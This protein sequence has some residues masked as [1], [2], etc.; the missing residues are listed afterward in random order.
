MRI[1]ITAFSLLFTLSLSAQDFRATAPEP[2]PAPEIELGDFQDF[3]L[4]NGLQ[5]VLVENHKLPR[6][7]YQLFVD[8]PPHLEGGYAGAGDIFGQLLRRATATKSKE[9]I[10]E[11]ID[12]IGAN[13]STSSTG[14]YASTITKYKDDVMAMMADIV[15]NARFPEEEFEKVKKETIDNL[16]GEL[17]NPDAIAARVRRATVYGP[18]HPY[19]ELNTEESLGNVDLDVVKAYY[20]SYFVPN[21]SYLIMVGDLNRAEAERMAR[22]HFSDW[23][24]KEVAVPEFPRPTPP[25]GVVVTFV[26]RDGAVQSNMI[27]A[28]PVELEPGTKEAIRANMLNTILGSGFNGRLFLN[29]RED[30]GYTYGAYSGISADPL[31]GNFRANAAVRNEVTDSAA[32]EFMYELEKISKEKV[33]DLELQRAKTQIAGTFGRALESPQRIAQYALNTVR[34]DLDRDFYPN[35]LK[36]VQASSANDLL[37]VAEE[38]ITPNNTHIIVVGDKA[39]AEKL[40]RFATSGKVNMVDANGMPVEESDMSADDLTVEGVLDMYVN[41]IGGMDAI[42]RIRNYKTVSS[43]TVQGQPMSM[44]MYKADGNKSAMTMSMMG[45]TLAD[46]RYN[47]GKAKVSQQG[48]PMPVDEEAMEGMAESAVLFPLVNLKNNLDD[49]SLDGVE[50]IDGK[51]VAVLNYRDGKSRHYIDL[52]TGEQIRY[53]QQQGPATAVFTLGDYRELGEGV[54]IP[55]SLK[56][57]GLAPF[58]LDFTVTEAAANTEIDPSVFAVD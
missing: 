30:K 20:D 33:T 1:L 17:N 18:N 4:D 7:S 28:H 11:A 39:T 40:A 44:T 41:A 24:A 32:T 21:R 50:K 47:D 45:M 56:I 36:R 55:H 22:E 46:Q 29:L 9:E 13:I 57:T 31:T 51:D 54:K 10:D 43:A 19:G 14:A 27:I 16:Q 6:V 23:E 38:L 42:N 58:P 48:Q 8:V 3:T 49:L 5:V 52:A 37:E 2:G 12:F 35:Y 25:E 53:V 26:P 15:L 34:Y